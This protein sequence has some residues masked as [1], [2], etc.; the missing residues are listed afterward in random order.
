MLSYSNHK[1][2]CKITVILLA[3]AARSAPRQSFSLPVR[4]AA[5]FYQTRV[6]AFSS[7]TVDPSHE[8]GRAHPFVERN[9]FSFPSLVLVSRLSPTF[10]DDTRREWFASRDTCPT[11]SEAHNAR[12]ART[13]RSGCTGRLVPAALSLFPS[14]IAS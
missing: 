1:I 12:V 4:L 8:R 7:V 11:N 10:H 3:L 13:M 14:M 9:F 2:S 5:N 6:I